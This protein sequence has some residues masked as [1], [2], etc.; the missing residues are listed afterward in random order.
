MMSG[1]RP[2]SADLVMIEK[3]MVGALQHLEHLARDP[4][5]PLLRLIGIGVAADMDG[6]R[7]GRL[8]WRARARAG[9]GVGL[10][11]QPALEVEAG[12]EADDRRGPAGHSN[13][14]SHARSPDRD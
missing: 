4:Q 1:S 2:I 5:A 8:A 14:C 6:R 11:E 10:E 12:R 9:A 7:P 13:R 3:R